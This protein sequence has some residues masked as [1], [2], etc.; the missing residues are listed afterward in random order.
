LF[1]EAIESAPDGVT[2]VV[3]RGKGQQARRRKTASSKI[4]YD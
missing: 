1:L 3:G 4:F 2:K